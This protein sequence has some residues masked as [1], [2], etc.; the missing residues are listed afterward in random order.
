MHVFRMAVLGCAALVGGALAAQAGV[1]MDPEA[2]AGPAAAAAGNGHEL[3]ATGGYHFTIPADFNGGIFGTIG[4]IENRLTFNAKRDADGTVSGWFT[5]HQ[6][7][8][9]SVFNFAGPVTCLRVYDTPVL[10]RTPEIPAQTHNRAKW[11]G[12]VVQSNDPTVPP[13]RYMWFSSIDNGEGANGY[14]DAS[15]IPGIGDQAA[16][17]A[18]CNADRVPNANFGPHRIGGGNIQVR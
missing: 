4:P 9:G 3:V 11:G 6:A 14:S 5:Y 2:E 15:S 16:N 7:V 18:F 17:E 1:G 8:D 12:L 10:V 13:G